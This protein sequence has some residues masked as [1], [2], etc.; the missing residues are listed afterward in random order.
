MK[1]AWW[2]VIGVILI[3]FFLASALWIMWR[4][5]PLPPNPCDGI[6]YAV[7][8]EIN[9]M[10]HCEVKEDCKVNNELDCPWG[11]YILINKNEEISKQVKDLSENYDQLCGVC[12]N[13]CMP[14]PEL[15][16]IDCINKKCVDLRFNIENL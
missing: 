4:P 2:I 8:Q 15:E 5:R 12:M 6:S 10:N 16:D 7:M 9:K 3:L 11:C 14:D 1:K 13:D